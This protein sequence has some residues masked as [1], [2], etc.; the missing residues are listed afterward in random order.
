VLQ[1]FLSKQQGEGWA[2]RF[3]IYSSEY[4][5]TGSIF[6]IKI[7]MKTEHN[8]AKKSMGIEKNCKISK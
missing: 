2:G 7:L 8:L 3:R 4:S 1:N 5:L 6:E